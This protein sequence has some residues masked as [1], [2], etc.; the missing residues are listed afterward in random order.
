MY[1]KLVLLLTISIS[2]F[3]SCRKEFS[4][5]NE[6]M[7]GTMTHTQKSFV[8]LTFDSK[9]S[10][11]TAKVVQ[12]LSGTV[13]KLGTLTANVEF[14]LDLSTGI[15]N[16]VPASYADKDGDKINT[17]SSSVMKGAELTIKETI[18]G[19]TG[20]FAKITGSGSQLVK[21]DFVTNIGA[22]VVEWTVTY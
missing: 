15:T 2:L 20:K 12:N 9:G 22:S 6:K 19:G 10:P 4:V 3:T 14:I 13:G 21:F 18:T 17:S 1:S 16:G 11:T 5:E 7:Q 8:P